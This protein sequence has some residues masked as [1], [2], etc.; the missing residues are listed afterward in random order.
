MYIDW[1]N[2]LVVD[3]ASSYAQ[4]AKLAETT[5]PDVILHPRS[6]FARH[7]IP[8]T[9]VSDN[10]PDTTPD[11]HMNLRGLSVKKAS[12][13]S[14]AA[15]VTLRVMAKPKCRPLKLK[16]RKYPS[17][18]INYIISHCTTLQLQS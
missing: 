17:I 8:E 2:L 7:G 5:S 15:H 11:I 9:V 12:Y 10:G 1:T 14:I 16:F 18:H 6:I 4:I 3:Y 13:T